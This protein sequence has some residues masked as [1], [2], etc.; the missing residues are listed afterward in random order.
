MTGFQLACVVC[1]AAGL[2]CCSSSACQRPHHHPSPP[3]HLSQK[4][5]HHPPKAPRPKHQ[6]RAKPRRLQSRR[7]HRRLPAP[8]RLRL[9]CAPQRCVHCS[10]C[11]TTTRCRVSCALAAGC[12]ACCR[13]ASQMR[14]AQTC[15]GRRR[16][17][18][19]ALYRRRSASCLKTRHLCLLQAARQQLVTLQNML[20]RPVTRR[21]AVSVTI[22]YRT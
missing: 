1:C 12:W 2:R 17:F 16:G 3:R 21:H 14:R 22:V 9:L 15:L 20:H 6:P 8:R 11:L 5:P 18:C 4:H 19:A 7:R 10:A 13:S